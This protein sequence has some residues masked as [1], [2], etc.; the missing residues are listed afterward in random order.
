VRHKMNGLFVELTLIEIFLILL[1]A[2]G[3]LFILYLLSGIFSSVT[4]KRKARAVAADETA[5][6]G[7][8]AE[9][10]SGGA[11]ADT[12]PEPEKPLDEKELLRMREDDLRKRENRLKEERMKELSQREKFISN[13]P[14]AV[15]AEQ[16]FG[17]QDDISTERKSI[18]DFIKTAEERHS[19]GELSE[20]NYRM[21]VSDYRQQLS[22]LDIKS[23]KQGGVGPDL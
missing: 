8:P 4:K 23:R 21:I 19:R 18:L 14:S 6:E 11:K 9:A 12:P 16:S 20:Q 2:F 13:R 10:S 5:F 3:L 7:E 17:G 22:E 15:E 1:L